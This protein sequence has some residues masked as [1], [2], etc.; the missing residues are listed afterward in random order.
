MIKDI[1]VNLEVNHSRDVTADYAI[2][3]ARRFKLDCVM[4]CWDGSRSA[5]RAVGDALPLLRRAKKLRNS[6]RVQ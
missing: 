6:P 1:V 5:A 2:T 3:L 4:V